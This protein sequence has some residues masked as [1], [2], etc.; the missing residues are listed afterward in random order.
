MSL[1]RAFKLAVA[2]FALVLVSP[3]AARELT[4]NPQQ[5]ERL[6]LQKPVESS[7]KAGESHEYQIDLSA[8][9]YLSVVVEQRGVDLT[10]R[11]L[12]NRGQTLSEVN[13]AK[14]PRGS[15]KLIFTADTD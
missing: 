1:Q 15:E 11:L 13:E 9:Q 3:V 5:A 6:E 10:A 14:G 8:G 7:L 12:S 2:W 4:L